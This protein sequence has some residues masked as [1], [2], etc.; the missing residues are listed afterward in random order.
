MIK[1]KPHNNSL[2]FILKTCALEKIEGNKLYLAFKYKFHKDRVDNPQI[3]NLMQKVLLEMFGESLEIET[4]INE[5]LEIQNIGSS[6][7]KSELNNS[8]VSKKN[9]DKSSE[10]VSTQKDVQNISK[11][12]DENNNMLDNVL[13]TFG[14]KVV[15]SG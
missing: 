9:E 1:I 14:G 11:D 8:P 2:A 4:V 6:D 5:N 13:K 15:R 3:K 7:M 12:N 10:E